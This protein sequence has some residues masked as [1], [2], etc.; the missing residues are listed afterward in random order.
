M[1]CVLVLLFAIIGH[2]A[3]M[4]SA[5]ADSPDLTPH[6]TVARGHSGGAGT[7]GHEPSSPH[8]HLVATDHGAE[9]CAPGHVFVRR[10]G[11]TPVDESGAPASQTVDELDVLPPAHPWNSWIEPGHP[12][13]RLRALLQVFLN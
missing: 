11:D 10:S 13:G 2:E 12:P 4:V 9:T 5:H 7:R 3:L 6:G 8:A 1:R